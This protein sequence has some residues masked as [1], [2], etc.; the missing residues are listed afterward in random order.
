ML[1]Y[2]LGGT[3][4]EKPEAY[5]KASPAKFISKDD[6]PTFFYHGARDRVVPKFSSAL[7]AAQLQTAGVEVEFYTVPEAGHMKSFL[8]KTAAEKAAA[9]LDKHLKAAAK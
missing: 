3:R 2:W 6:P 9:F 8:D 7:M 5:A 4:R 1:A